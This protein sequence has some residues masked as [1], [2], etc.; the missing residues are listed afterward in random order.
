MDPLIEDLVLEA[1]NY[2]EKGDWTKAEE[3][4]NKIFQIKLN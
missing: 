4:T 3:L 1:R 2:A